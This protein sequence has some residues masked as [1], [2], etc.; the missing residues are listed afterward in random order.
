ML[1]EAI[2]K[3]KSISKKGSKVIKIMRNKFNIKIK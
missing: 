1:N 3:I 2:S